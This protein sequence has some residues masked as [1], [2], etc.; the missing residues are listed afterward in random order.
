MRSVLIALNL[1]KIICGMLCFLVI[2]SGCGQDSPTRITDEDSFTYDSDTLSV[3]AILQCS[4]LENYRDIQIDSSIII[5]TDNGRV[6]GLTFGYMEL[7]SVPAD[8]GNLSA[9]KYLDLGDNYFTELPPEIGSLV[10]LETLQ[11]DFT[12]LES[13]PPEIGNLHALK[14]LCLDNNYHLTDFP[15]EIANIT[16]LEKLSLTDCKLSVFPLPIC[17]LISLRVLD[18]SS[19]AL[20]SVPAGIGDLTGLDTLFL[21]NNQITTLPE[22]ITGL[23][24]DS[25]DIAWNEICVV[26]SEI[27][28]W[29]S[30]IDSLWK[31]RQFCN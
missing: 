5:N 11:M 31:S 22:S 10:N 15:G 16:A 30:Q 12:S 28:Q 9:L 3:R 21:K 18:L 13:L 4:R 23:S 1:I 17:R 8:I 6:T 26:N 14:V 7:T 20:T 29:L 19:N 25:L 27:D 2:L 24:L